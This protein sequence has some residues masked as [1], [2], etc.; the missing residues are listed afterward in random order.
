MPHLNS[1]YLQDN[2]IHSIAP[3]HGAPLLAILNLASNKVILVLVIS[4][5]C[6]NPDD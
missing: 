5:I 6:R 2:N 1:L 3:M 4:P